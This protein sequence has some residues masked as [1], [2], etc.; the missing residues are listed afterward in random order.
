[1]SEICFN[2]RQ[3]YSKEGQDWCYDCLTEQPKE[4]EKDEDGSQ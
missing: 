3:Y 2:C 1:M 4:I